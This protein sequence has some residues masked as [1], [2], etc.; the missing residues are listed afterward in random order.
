MIVY[1]TN[2]YTVA[3]AFTA[4][5]AGV[6]MTL[7]QTNASASSNSHLFYLVGAPPVMDNIVVNS[8]GLFEQ[9]SLTVYMLNGVNQTTP[10]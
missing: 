10:I 6:P 2:S 7:L 5:F 4:T 3:G 1:V 8:A 9:M